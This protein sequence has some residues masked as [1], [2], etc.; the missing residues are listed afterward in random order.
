LEKD[1]MDRTAVH[2]DEV[3]IDV[4]CGPCIPITSYGVPDGIKTNPQQPCSIIIFYFR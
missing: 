4:I 1:L 2:L 3:V